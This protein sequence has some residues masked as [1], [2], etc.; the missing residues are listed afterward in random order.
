MPFTLY[1]LGH[2]YIGLK[3]DPST[4]TLNKVGRPT[5]T[6]RRFCQWN[7][8]LQREDLRRQ[9]H[10]LLW[11]SEQQCDCMGSIALLVAISRCE[12]HES[13]GGWWRL[14]LTWPGH[15]WR[16]LSWWRPRH[17]ASTILTTLLLSELNTIFVCI[18]IRE[19]HIISIIYYSI[20]WIKNNIFITNLNVQFNTTL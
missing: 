9:V 2:Y 13:S 10:R 4:N 20:Y 17:Q 8:L 6:D 11:A 12:V 18:N 5:I 15:C 3:D 19:L 14:R 16:H 7:K 1:T